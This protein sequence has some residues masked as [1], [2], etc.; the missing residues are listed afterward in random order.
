MTLA[1]SGRAPQLEAIVIPES[2]TLFIQKLRAELPEWKYKDSTQDD[3]GE[4]TNTTSYE[5]TSPANTPALAETLKI[6]EADGQI[7]SARLTYI[8]ESPASEVVHVEPRTIE[9]FN[10]QTAIFDRSQGIVTL[11]GNERGNMDKV[12]RLA[13]S[14]KGGSKQKNM[15]FSAK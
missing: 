2:P 12:V 10:P 11:Y 6:T 13:V 9:A 15:G 7:L 4:S 14:P 8:H 5:F 1:E 3:K